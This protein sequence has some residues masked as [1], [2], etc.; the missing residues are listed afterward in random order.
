LYL[1]ANYIEGNDRHKIEK[2]IKANPDVAVFD[3][4]DAVSYSQK[5][6]A[7]ETVKDALVQLAPQFRA[8]KIET[9]VRI[10][11][12]DSGLEEDDIRKVLSH[13]RPDGIVI[14]KVHLSIYIVTLYKVESASQLHKIAKLLGEYENRNYVSDMMNLE[15]KIAEERK[16]DKD[17]NYKKLTGGCNSCYITDLNIRAG[18]SRDT[19][20]NVYSFLRN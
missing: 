5:S 17:F 19:N 7:R 6:A 4:E 16:K 2:V 20:Q 10:N 12:V 15:R 13:A 8:K 14:P 3:L 9:L 18:N 1:L 11:Q